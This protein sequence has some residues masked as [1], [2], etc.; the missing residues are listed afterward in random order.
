MTK[1]Y[2]WLNKEHSLRIIGTTKKEALNRVT[3]VTK[4]LS[5]SRKVTPKELQFTYSFDV[6]RELRRPRQH[7]QLGGAPW[8]LDITF[9]DNNISKK[10]RKKKEE[11]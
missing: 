10:Y 2:W 4:E 5:R 7:V 11:K 9:E 8:A 3:E 1:K 6:E